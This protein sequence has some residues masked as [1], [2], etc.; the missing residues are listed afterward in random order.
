MS[1]KHSISG[2]WVGKNNEIAKRFYENLEFM[3]I[4]KKGKWNIS[5]YENHENI[6]AI[7]SNPKF[8]TGTHLDAVPSWGHPYAFR[9]KQYNNKIWGKGAVDT[10][11]QI[12]PFLWAMKDGNNFFM[13]FFRDEEERGIGSK[14][15]DITSTLNIKGAI[16]R[17][18]A[19]LKMCI[20]QAGSIEIE[21]EIEIIIKGKAVH[22][23]TVKA[24]ENTIKKFFIFFNKLNSLSSIIQSDLFFHYF[25]INLAYIKGR[26]YIQTV[27]E[28]CIAKIGSMLIDIQTITKYM[29]DIEYRIIEKSDF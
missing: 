5:Y 22:S 29:H 15:F 23:T 24:G 12:A 26:I 7:K 11:G 14:H 1:Q 17:E 20:S 19:S 4:S 27:S 10:K 28:L 2:L 13:I 16:I 3:Y 25:D 21:I 9:P 6:Y 8:I 18:T